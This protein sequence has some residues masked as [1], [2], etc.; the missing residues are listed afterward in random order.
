[1]GQSAITSVNLGV[2]AFVQSF[3][4]GDLTAGIL[5]VTHNL[6]KQYVSVTVYNNSD[7]IIIPDDVTATSVNVSTIDLLSFGTLT[8]TWQAVIHAR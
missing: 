7:L 5:T 2:P 4:N 8:G 3:T 6:N 1:M